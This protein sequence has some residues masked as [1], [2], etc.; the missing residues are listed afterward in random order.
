MILLMPGLSSFGGREEQSVSAPAPA[1]AFGAASGV[2]V[3][4]DDEWHD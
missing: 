3:G 1:A 2:T 4:N